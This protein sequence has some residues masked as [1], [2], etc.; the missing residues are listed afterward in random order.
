MQSQN[1]KTRTQPVS[2]GSQPTSVRLQS[3]RSVLTSP[4]G[5]FPLAPTRAAVSP[6]SQPDVTF[7][8]PVWSFQFCLEAAGRCDLNKNSVL[9]KPMQEKK[10]HQ[11]HNPNLTIWRVISHLKT[12][13]LSHFPCA[14]CRKA[15]KCQKCSKTNLLNRFRR[16]LDEEIGSLLGLF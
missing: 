8:K 15:A 12:F 13:L 14:A 4:T 9:L 5:R 16:S 2:A 10:Q 1:G 6:S 3:K 11:L 7:H